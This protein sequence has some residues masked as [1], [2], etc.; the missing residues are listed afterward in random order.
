[1]VV[2]VFFSYVAILSACCGRVA[3]L[4]GRHITLAVSDCVFMLVSRHLGL[5]NY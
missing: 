2:G 3:G 5:R 4:W 1:M